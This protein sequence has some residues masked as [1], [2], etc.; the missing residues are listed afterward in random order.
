MVPVELLQN[1]YSIV[2][3]VLLLIYIIIIV[4]IFH[5]TKVGKQLEALGISVEASIQTGLMQSFYL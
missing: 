2:R 1:D 3:L 5:K 4:I